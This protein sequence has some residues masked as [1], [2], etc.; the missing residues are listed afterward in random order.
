MKRKKKKK[1]KLVPLEKKKKRKRKKKKKK[2][3]IL[4]LFFFSSIFTDNSKWYG[5]SSA[6]VAPPTLSLQNGASAV[7]FGEGAHHSLIKN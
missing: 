3:R 5:I 6:L 7:L 2:K 4:S 1:K